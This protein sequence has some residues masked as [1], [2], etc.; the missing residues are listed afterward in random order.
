MCWCNDW[1]VERERERERERG[2]GD[3]E[4]EKRDSE[5]EREEK[6]K[7]ERKKGRERERDIYSVGEVNDWRRDKIKIKR[8]EIISNE[9][10]TGKLWT[11]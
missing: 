10:E 1:Y 5:K 11:T 7:K 4:R 2:E 3:K 9:L 8:R 6:R